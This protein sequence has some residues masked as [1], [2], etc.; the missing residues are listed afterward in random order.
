M[1]LQVVVAV[2]GGSHSAACK[3]VGFLGL[4][5]KVIALFVE[6]Y[7]SGVHNSRLDNVLGQ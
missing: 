2:V 4:A 1:L 7:L 5:I 3:V 6:K